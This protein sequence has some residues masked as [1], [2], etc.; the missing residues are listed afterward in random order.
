MNYKAN[1]SFRAYFKVRNLFDKWYTDQLYLM[2]PDSTNWYSAP[3]RN[4]QFGVE[5]RF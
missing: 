2:D 3:G 1:E 5:Y 4:Y